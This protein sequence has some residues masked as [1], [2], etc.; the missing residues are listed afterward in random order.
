[1]LYGRAGY[2]LIVCVVLVLVLIL[3]VE[4]VVQWILVIIF[5]MN[6]YFWG[7]L[8]II[9]I[10]MYFLLWMNFNFQKK[11]AWILMSQI[12]YLILI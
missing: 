6:F 12:F 9:G 7:N 5:F 1:M 2:F 11:K 3:W 10:F 4:V 8:V